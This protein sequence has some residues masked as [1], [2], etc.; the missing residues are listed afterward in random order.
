MS[1]SIL[2]IDTP[3]TCSECK[4]FLDLFDFPKCL[5][6]NESKDYKFNG[7]KEKMDS[8]PLSLLPQKKS[9]YKYIQRGDAKSMLHLVHDIHDQGWNDCIDNILKAGE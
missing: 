6:T 5:V 3:E 4:F 2:I 7:Y 8:C 1:K 9:A